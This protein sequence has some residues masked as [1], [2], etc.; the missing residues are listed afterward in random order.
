MIEKWFVKPFF[1]T[2]FSRGKIRYLPRMS[3]FSYAA[4]REVSGR[5]TPKRL[6]ERIPQALLDG[7]LNTLLLNGTEA[8]N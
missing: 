8:G 4:Q 2:F 3:V 7:R 1:T 5:L 6:D